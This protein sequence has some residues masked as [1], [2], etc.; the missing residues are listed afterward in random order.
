MQGVQR[1]RQRTA[2]PDHD[3]ELQDHAPVAT[4]GN[5]ADKQR[6]QEQRY[7]LRQANHA[8]QERALL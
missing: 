2:G 1:Q 6:Q 4:V 5:R 8:D 7:K 3:A